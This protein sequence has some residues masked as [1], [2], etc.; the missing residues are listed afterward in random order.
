MSKEQ[1]RLK[2]LLEILVFPNGGF[3]FPNGIESKFRPAIQTPKEKFY[4]Q[5]SSI[6]GIY[7]SSKSYCQCK[8]GGDFKP[9][10]FLKGSK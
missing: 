8:F 9:F 3:F 6:E 4:Q 5:V 2:T 10:P 7:T 1:F